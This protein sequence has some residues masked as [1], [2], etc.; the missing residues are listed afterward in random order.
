MVSGIL[1]RKLAFIHSANVDKPSTTASP[2]MLSKS[3]TVCATSRA[4]NMGNTSTA[5]QRY[6]MPCAPALQPFT[7][8]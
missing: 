1:D 8:L 7:R 3:T 6:E 2:R 5:L 4:R